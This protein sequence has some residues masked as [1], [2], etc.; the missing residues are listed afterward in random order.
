MTI[1]PKIDFS[2]RGVPREG[3]EHDE[4]K[5]RKQHIGRLVSA[6]MNHEDKDAL[7]ADVRGKH[8][9]T[10][11]SEESNRCIH[12]QEMSKAS[13]CAKCFRC[14]KCLMEGIVHCDCGACLVPTRDTT[15]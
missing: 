6:L 7:L 4:G 11:F 12:P 5:S 14:V 15:S 8:L 13:N 1:A 2:F 10:P 9:Y 3:L